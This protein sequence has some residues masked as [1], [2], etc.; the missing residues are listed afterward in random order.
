MENLS[1]FFDGIGRNPKLYIGTSCLNRETIGKHIQVLRNLKLTKQTHSGIVCGVGFLTTQ[2]V[3]ELNYKRKEDTQKV[4]VEELKTMLRKHG[5][6]LFTLLHHF[7]GPDY[8][9]RE[10]G[11]YDDLNRL[12]RRI[13]PHLPDAI[14]IN[15]A[16]LPWEEL[17]RLREEYPV[18]RN[19]LILQ[20]IG[21]K[22]EM[23]PLEYIEGYADVVSAV[24]I[25][26]SAGEGIG[27]DVKYA[28]QTMIKINERFPYLHISVAGGFGPD[29]IAQ[30]LESILEELRAGGKPNLV[31]SVDAQSKIRTKDTEHPKR[32]LFDTGKARRYLTGA[33]SVLEKVV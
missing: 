4:E 14:Q 5:A 33:Y 29:N 11:F 12:F 32:G 17:R 20:V 18:L 24:I 6:E 27:I 15:N 25:D 10:G 16:H 28:A 9:C 8:I 7:R 3:L 26:P 1:T 2:N 13:S 30:E 31:Y 19:R 22:L 21:K 23:D